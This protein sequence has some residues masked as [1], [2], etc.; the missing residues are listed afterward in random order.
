MD[1]TLPN[2][3]FTGV[4]PLKGPFLGHF[5]QG[6]L[7]KVN[8]NAHFSDFRMFCCFD[9]ASLG[10]FSLLRLVVNISFLDLLPR[11]FEW[12][13]PECRKERNLLQ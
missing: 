10:C 9:P 5:S 6:N 4:V 13:N 1:R 2:A 8:E 3:F 11:L 7:S 12:S